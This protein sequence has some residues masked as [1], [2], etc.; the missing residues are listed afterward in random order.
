MTNTIY[1]K[2]EI[3]RVKESYDFQ[4]IKPEAGDTVYLKNRGNVDV[5]IEEIYNG[6]YGKRYK[7]TYYDGNEYRVEW[8]FESEIIFGFHGVFRKMMNAHGHPQ[9]FHI[10][11]NGYNTP[12]CAQCHCCVMLNRGHGMICYECDHNFSME[13][14]HDE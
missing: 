6:K 8:V 7:C 9:V 12:V 4:G 1:S 3:K 5:H 10:D 13:C 14:A 2:E 11:S